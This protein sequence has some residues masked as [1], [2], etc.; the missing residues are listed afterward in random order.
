MNHMSAAMH[1]LPELTE[2]N[3]TLETAIQKYQ[4]GRE[5]QMRVICPHLGRELGCISVWPCKPS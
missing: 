1:T 2:E 5:D 3:G 4:L